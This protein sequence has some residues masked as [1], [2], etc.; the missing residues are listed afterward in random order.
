[1]INPLR[2]VYLNNRWY[3]YEPESYQETIPL[4]NS[5][6]EIYNGRDASALGSTLNNYTI[7]L[8][9]D[10]TY[11]VRNGDVEL[12]STTWLGVSRRADLAQFAGAKGISMPIIFVTPYGHTNTVMPTGQLNLSIFNS[13]N[14]ESEA[15]VEFRVSLTLQE[16]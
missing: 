13:S 10:S 7:T 15:G 4:R 2:G 1:M 11:T 9:L 16:L 3:N 5:L 12:G 8:V 14:P 6:R